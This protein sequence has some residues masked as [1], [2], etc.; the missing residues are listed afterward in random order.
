M[1]YAISVSPE[2]NFLI[3]TSVGMNSFLQVCSLSE[4]AILLLL[5]RG[6][7]ESIHTIVLI[8]MMRGPR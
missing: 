6:T 4:N 2:G 7:N 3:N 5:D 1:L 8:D